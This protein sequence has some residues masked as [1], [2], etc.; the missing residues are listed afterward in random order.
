VSKISQH[1]FR[2]ILSSAVRRPRDSDWPYD[3]A[4]L[5]EDLQHVVNE[6]MWLTTPE[7]DASKLFVLPDRIAVFTDINAKRRSVLGQC[8]MD[9]DDETALVVDSYLS[10]KDALFFARLV[11][12]GQESLVD[13]W[14]RL[15][16]PGM[17]SLTVKPI[18]ENYQI[19]IAAISS[20]VSCGAS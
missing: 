1:Q 4:T 2:Q 7:S 19:M 13:A 10:G 5:D 12:A 14:V 8:L 6:G 11:P 3:A 18:D 20:F 16:T 15:M 17:V 9:R